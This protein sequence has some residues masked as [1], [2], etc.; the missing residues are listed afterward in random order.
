MISWIKTTK[1][2]IKENPGFI[3]FDVCMAHFVLPGG[4]VALWLKRKYKLPYVLVSHG[5]EIP[6]VHPKQMFFFH[7]GAYFWLKKVCKY[8]AYNFIQTQM[9]KDNI[10]AFLGEK[11]K[12]K[13][14][15]VP[16]GI[17]PGKFFPDY[18]KRGKKLRILFVGRLVLQKDPM[19]FL[20]AVN[21]LKA[22]T[23]NFEVHILG[24]GELKTKMKEYVL[25]NNL[26]EYVVFKGKVAPEQM[27]AEYQAAHLMVAPSLNEGM[28]IAALEALACGVYIIASRASGFEDMI[29]ERVNGELCDFG[30]WRGLS[31]L[32]VKVDMIKFQLENIDNLSIIDGNKTFDWKNIVN[33]YNHLLYKSIG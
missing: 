13:N 3:D 33:K 19:T 21:F 6:W 22:S 30:D 23:N 17:D 9:M 32:I 24:G 12:K 8:S 28:S 25:N 27:L 10:D 31:D 29:T 16:N 11:Y 20:K 14:V 15:I 1:N 4:E 26:R 18:S 2:F 7:L 5:H